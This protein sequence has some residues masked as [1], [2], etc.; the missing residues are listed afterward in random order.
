MGQSL[1]QIYLHLVFSTNNRAPFLQD[2]ILRADTHAYLGGACRNLHC[3]PLTIGGVEDNVHILC[4]LTRD[5]SV[6]VLVR[7][8]KRF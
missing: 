8:L 4:R 5:L 7:E 1:A 3:P 2:K 6:A